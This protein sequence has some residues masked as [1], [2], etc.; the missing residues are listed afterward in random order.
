MRAPSRTYTNRQKLLGLQKVVSHRTLRTRLLCH[1][2]PEPPCRASG[3]SQHR[4]GCGLLRVSCYLQALQAFCPRNKADDAVPPRP[5]EVGAVGREGDC[6]G[7]APSLLVEGGG[8][9]QEFADELGLIWNKQGRVSQTQV[10][11]WG[12][13]GWSAAREPDWLHPDKNKKN[14][15]TRRLFLDKYE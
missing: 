13:G 7:L 1:V 6:P 12:W 11:W 14:H 3:E 8:W 9:H 5:G 10:T 15:V 2:R 4:P